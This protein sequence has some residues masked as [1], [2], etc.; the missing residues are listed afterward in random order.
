MSAIEKCVIK[1]VL[2][3]SKIFFLFVSMIAL[4]NEE[5]CFLFHLKSSFHYHDI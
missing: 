3:P 5:K 2:S 4:Q 1:V